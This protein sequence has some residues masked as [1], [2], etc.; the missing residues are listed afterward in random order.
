MPKVICSKYKNCNRNNCPHKT[1][2]DPVNIC[3][4]EHCNS[5]NRVVKCV[6]PRKFKLKQLTKNAKSHL[7]KI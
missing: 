6:N 4:N 1:E 5:T 3:G 2:H 7:Y